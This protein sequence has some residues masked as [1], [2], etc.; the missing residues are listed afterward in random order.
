MGKQIDT[1]ARRHGFWRRLLWLGPHTCPWWLGWTFDNP[2]RRR[3]HDAE[4]ILGPFVK[5]GDTV[6]DIGCGLGYFSL[7]MARLVGPGGK[8]IAA[9]IQ[10]QML[11]RCR[12]RLERLQL[13]DRVTIHLCTQNSLAIREELDFALAF[14]VIHEIENPEKLLKD[15]QSLLKPAGRL[16]IVEPKGHVSH[17]R[18][19]ATVELA[20]RTGYTVLAGPEIRFSRAVTCYL[21]SDGGC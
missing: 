7:E 2:I 14:W 8:V 4:A 9:D 18:F 12:R 15:L 21:P 16:L 3:V 5:E 10:P 1:S 11:Q 13:A 6:I 20:R 17:K 19:E